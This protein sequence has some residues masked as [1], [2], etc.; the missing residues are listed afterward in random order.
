MNPFHH[1]LEDR[2]RGRRVTATSN[3]GRTVTGWVERLEYTNR[4]VVLVDAYTGES[5]D[6]KHLGTAFLSHV[7]G[8][9]LNPS[10]KA[11]EP[12]YQRPEIQLRVIDE[13]KNH[14]FHVREFDREENAQYITEVR[15]NGW[16]GSYPRARKTDHGLELFSGHKRM[17]AAK[18]AGLHV[19]PVE[20]YETSGWKARME[21]FRDHF[22][23][24]DDFWDNG[25][26]KDGFY[27]NEEIIEVLEMLEG[28]TTEVTWNIP[29]VEYNARRL[30]F[31]DD[32]FQFGKEVEEA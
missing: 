13:I 9:Y 8:M 24:E 12:R 32:D 4:H 19:H 17:W 11:P 15:E 22:P 20:V 6:G 29:A 16:V 30:G 3:D 5:A 27:S 2:F 25:E 7:D 26:T 23:L 18:Q 31:I 10:E 28:N 14:P 21:F 1:S